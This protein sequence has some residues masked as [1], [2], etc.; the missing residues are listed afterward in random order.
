MRTAIYLVILLMPLRLYAEITPVTLLFT[1]DIESAYDPVTAFWR[2]DLERIGGIAELATLIQNYRA[3]HSNV[4]LFDAGDIY[5][6]TLAKR[7][8]GAVSFDLLLTMGYDAMA[9][10]NHE[11]E[12]G[13]EELARQKNRVSFPVLGA[14]LFYRD[15]DHP[16]AQPYAIVERNGI[17][18]GVIGFLGQDA[19]TA[20]IP[21]NIAGL[22]VRDPLPILRRHVSLL[23][24][25]VDL[26]VV[27]SHQ[28]PTAPMQTDDEADPTVH[29]GNQE[30]LA[31][32]GAIPGI[33]VILAGHTDAGTR[34]PLIHPQTGTLIM[35][36][37]GQAQHLGVVHLEIDASGKRV[38]QRGQL[39]EVQSDH[40][41]PDPRVAEKLALYRNMHTDIYTQ[42]G[43]NAEYLS[44]RY[45]EESDLGN[46]FADILRTETGA[47]I[48][49]VPSGALRKDLPM[50]VVR[51]IDLLDAFPF[52]DHVAL[53]EVSGQLLKAILEQGLS[54]ERGL[55]QASGLIA[56]Y[57]P[58]QPAGQRLL[59]VHIDGERLQTNQTYTIATL[60]I[61]ARGGDAYV[62]FKEAESTTMQK[63]F[64]EVLEAYFGARDV[65]EKPQ[66]GRLIQLDQR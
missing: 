51:K 32:A 33:D 39:V 3:E 12:F 11:F 14:N 55:L 13:W 44:R 7:T 6:G 1:N 49:L 40:L 52:E 50:G 62:Q 26:V 48:G 31:L 23:R 56:T 19:G 34:T 41:Q 42:V 47:Q 16:Y 27:L 45:Y 9:I 20:L 46:L 43:S 64:A 37:Y 15:T 60:E 24:D 8:K 65:V 4:F 59:E 10:G 53:V 5:T 25:T 63:P 17:R 2:D 35:Q 28:G 58:T 38:A 18:V 61:L 57:D 22:E 29:R 21:S 66:R 54:L 30:N 36:T